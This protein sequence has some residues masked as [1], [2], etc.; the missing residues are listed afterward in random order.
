MYSENNHFYSIDL[1]TD[2]IN[3][4]SNSILA[5]KS[6]DDNIEESSGMFEGHSNASDSFILRIENG[7]DNFIVMYDLSIRALQH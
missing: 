6:N 4:T 2:I 7:N 5:A 1:S 3:N